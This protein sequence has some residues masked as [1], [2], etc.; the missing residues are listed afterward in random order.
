MKIAIILN[1]ISRKKKKFYQSILPPL[2]ENFSIEIFETRFAN[3]AHQ[4]A[5]KAVIDKY[6][7]ILSAG[8]DGT[9]HQV[10]N[11]MMSV[12]H[13]NQLPTLGLIPLGSGNDFANTI[14]AT[15]NPA[16]LLELL[17]TN[18]P[19]LIDLGKLICKDASNQESVKYFINACSVGMGPA[20]VKQMTKAPPWLGAELRYLQSIVRAF[21]AHIPEPIEIKTSDWNWVGNVRVLAIANGK[22][23]GSK[24]YIAPDAKPDDGVF[25]T[26]LVSDIPLLKFLFY[27]QVVK[28]KKKIKDPSVAY[29]TTT[30]IEITSS[31]SVAIEAEGELMG[32]L[33]AAV[34]LL[35]GQ[36]KFL[37]K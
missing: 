5:T 7:I 29:S 30:K 32:F 9:L 11:G 14:G 33:P 35:S 16:E 18:Q 31:Q 25:S 26:F 12:A 6:D 24:I 8:G 19:R 34:E 3:H 17:S 37:C 2:R 36:I 23:F 21:L 4:L 1:G 22:S 10:V 13:Q 27:L 20:T 28:N 15:N